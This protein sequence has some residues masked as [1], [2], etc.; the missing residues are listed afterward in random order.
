MFFF[1]YFKF[2]QY[3]CWKISITFKQC[4]AHFIPNEST[5]C[6][7]LAPQR[8]SSRPRATLF[9]QAKES[10]FFFSPRISD[11]KVAHV[12]VRAVGGWLEE[13][14]GPI[15]RLGKGSLLKSSL[16]SRFFRSFLWRC[17][18]AGHSSLASSS[19]KS[20]SISIGR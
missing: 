7:N 2:Y 17:T 13:T 3:L 20:H 1:F 5:K 10:L 14:G 11:E 18:S 8:I 12:S 4:N 6:K 16:K 15:R 9:P 19:G